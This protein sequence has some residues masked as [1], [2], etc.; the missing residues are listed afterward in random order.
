MKIW[1]HLNGI[2]QGPYELSQLHQLPIEAST[3]VWYEGLPGWTSAAE[4]PATAPMFRNADTQSQPIFPTPQPAASTTTQH[5]QQSSDYAPASAYAENT[6][7]P[8]TYIGWSILL[9]VLCCSPLAVVA[10]ITGAISSSRYNSGDYSGAKS[11]SNLTEWLLIF[12]I[13]LAFITA[14]LGMSWFLL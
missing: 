5:T 10:I 1:I 9:A 11:M 4:A 12:T 13:V 8:P 7:Q 14:P 6:K 2:Q 3:P